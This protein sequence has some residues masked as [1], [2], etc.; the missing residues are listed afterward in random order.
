M[1]ADGSDVTQ[2]THHGGY[3]A[4]E[5]GDNRSI[6]FSKIDAPGL[7]SVPVGGGEEKLVIDRLRRGYWSHWTIA[8]DS[9]YFIDANIKSSP[10]LVKFSLLTRQSEEFKAPEGIRDWLWGLAVSPDGNSLVGARTSDLQC[11]VMLGKNYS[12][13]TRQ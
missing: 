11:N 2:I 6:L 7:W 1:S 9:V 3:R 12:Q 4:I 5:A 8:D 13:V 10:T